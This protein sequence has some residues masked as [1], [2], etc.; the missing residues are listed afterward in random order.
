MPALARGSFYQGCLFILTDE[1][2][3]CS[4]L[5]CLRDSSVFLREVQNVLII[6]HS[7]ECPRIEVNRV[8]K[9]S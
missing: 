9:R 6:S 4:G 2:R 1:D 7:R 5:R 3:R 8:G